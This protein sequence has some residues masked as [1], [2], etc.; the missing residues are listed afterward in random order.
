MDNLKNSYLFFTKPSE[1][2]LWDINYLVF[3]VNL[4]L[5]KVFFI[6]LKWTIDLSLIKKYDF[7][8]LEIK[9]LND[10]LI[11][12]KSNF[13]IWYW[14]WFWWYPFD[15]LW[16]FLWEFSKKIRVHDGISLDKNNFNFYINDIEDSLINMF[17]IYIRFYWFFNVLKIIFYKIIRISVDNYIV[18]NYYWVLEFNKII[19]NEKR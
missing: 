12:D 1:K 13:I 15:Q 18:I 9:S 6:Y 8:F 17:F 5:E 10:I 14:R 19:D 7:N 11:L 16:Y 2:Y 4:P 3:K